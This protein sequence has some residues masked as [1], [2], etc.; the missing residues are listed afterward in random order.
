M[1]CTIGTFTSTIFRAFCVVD[2]CIKAGISFLHGL[3]WWELGDT[4]Q[5]ARQRTC[6]CAVRVEHRLFPA[7]S[8][9]ASTAP[10]EPRV[11][12]GLL[13]TCLCATT[14]RSTHLVNVLL[15]T[16]LEPEEFQFA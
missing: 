1:T 4:S 13:E 14:G 7:P 6:L 11:R 12:F 8:A 2:T 5:F 16:N 9:L 15:L 10:D 3:S